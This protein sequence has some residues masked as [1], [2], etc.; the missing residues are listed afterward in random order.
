ML[1]TS[2]RVR[3]ALRRLAF[4]VFAS[5]AIAH[6]HSLARAEDAPSRPV[7]AKAPEQHS[8][9]THFLQM[10]YNHPGLVVDLAVG[11]WAWPLP[12]DLNGDGRTDIVVSCPDKPS[13]GTYVFANPGAGSEASPVFRPGRRLSKGLTNAQV[14]FVDG[15]PRVLAPGVEFPD[16]LKT[17]FER[18][19]KLTPPSNIHANKV[20]ANQWRYVDYDGDGK[21]DLVVG[22]EDWTDYGWDNGYDAEGKWQRGPLR[23]FV[24][25]LRNEGTNAEPKY[26]T[27]QKLLA[28]GVPLETFGMP[29]PSFADFKNNGKLDL[30]CGEFLDGFT[31][32]ENIGTRT[33]PEYA[34]GRRLQAANRQPLAMDLQM[35][36]PTAFDWDGDGRMDLVCGDEDGR[37]AWLRNTGKV[38]DGAPVFLSPSYFQQEADTLK[39]GALATPVAVDWD[40]DGDVDLI[41]GNTA[42]YVLFFEN[43][44]GPGVEHPKWAAPRV[45]EADSKVLRIMAGPNGSIQG[46]AEAKW[47]YT[48]LSVT[49]WDGDGLP[50]LIVNSIWGRVVWYKN[51]GSRKAPKLAAPQSV[52]VEWEGAPPELAWG[53]LKPQGKALLTQWR[54]TPVVV[55]LN[56]D[57]L[58]DLVMLDHEGYLVFFERAER[59]GKRVL[60]SPRRA[61]CDE[62]GEPL[63]LNNRTA[64]GSGRRKLSAVDWDGDG[65]VDFLLNSKNA[66]LLRQVATTGGKWLFKDMGPLSEDN[67]E[68]HDTSPTT[69]DFNNDGIPDLVVGAEDGRFYYLR[70]RRS[71]A[72][73]R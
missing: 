18:P 59:G 23:G 43:L 58:P 51:I 71:A 15:K 28:G 68:G 53:W 24:Y 62:A 39:C 63:R 32:F 57:G 33:H 1:L 70:N 60:L 40:G 3:S 64:G 31:Y 50:D 21:L 27:P 8:S 44:S 36:T 49:D 20:R 69:G 35:I 55:D 9:S 52:E 61:L 14:S 29:S 47:G 30:I 22:V 11:L 65:K 72:N 17:G 13:N 38:A 25:L 66:T 6:T 67:I 16:F 56:G 2:P 48:T 37:V 41:A 26:E 19:Q 10:P 5:C 34:R 7:S 46:P 42:G 4:L 73:G 12:M 54:T 45:L